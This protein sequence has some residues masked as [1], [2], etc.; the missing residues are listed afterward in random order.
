MDLIFLFI[1]FIST[2]CYILGG[3]YNYSGAG[4]KKGSAWDD[5]GD[6]E[7]VVVVQGAAASAPQLAP[8][9]TKKRRSLGLRKFSDL[10]NMLS[11]Y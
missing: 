8:I 9:I 3:Y 2:N 1:L 7:E 10:S 5:D 6:D 11:L 4:M